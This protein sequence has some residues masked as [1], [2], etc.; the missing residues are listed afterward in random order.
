MKKI[1]LLIVNVWAA[2]SMVFAQGVKF[3]E[4]TWEEI[5]S[6]AQ[7][8]NKEIFVDVYTTWCGPCKHVATKV[9]PLEKMGEVYNERFINFQVDAESPAGKK[10]A[11]K[12]GVKAFP[13]FLYMTP[14][15]ELIHYLVG[16]KSVDE[17][18]QEVQ[19]L[20]VYRKHGGIEAI[21]AAIETGTASRELLYDCYQAATKDKKPEALNRYLKSLSNEELVDSENMLIEEITLYDRE[22]ML[23][24]I[25][26]VT[27][28]SLTPQFQEKEFRSKFVFNIAFSVEYFISTQIK[29]SIEA[30]DLKFFNEMLELKERFQQYK[31]DLYDGDLEITEGRGL[32]FATTDY[33]H[34]SYWYKNKVNEEEFKSKLP[35]YMEQLLEKYPAGKL[36][37]TVGYPAM[38]EDSLG[39]QDPTFKLF[40]GG[41]VWH[42][43]MSVQAI[44]NWIDYFWKI[45]PSD[46]ATR[47]LCESWLKA[48]VAVNPLNYSAAISAAD[49]LARLDN[50]KD[51]EMM[52]TEALAK[53]QAMKN[54]IDK[55][56]ELKLRFIKNR[57]L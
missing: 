16:A 52:L 1:V 25:D 7:A 2:C 24:L 30:G 39:M 41:I 32:F 11:K 51:A 57:K 17:F 28:V 4:G 50:F 6:K 18:L 54:N 27:K 49:M 14:E 42:G 53:Q 46:K 47:R 55:N 8:Q 35:G 43:N 31:G 44:I 45:S 26:E 38:V 56:L 34:F 19:M 36:M 40:F 22:L 10:L 29:K 33:L 12:W 13:T 3:E 37:D 20:K 23:R 9:F 48:L 5:L 15:G 21:T